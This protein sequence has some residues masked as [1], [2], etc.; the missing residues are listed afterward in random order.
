MLKFNKQEIYL[1]FEGLKCLMNTKKYSYKDIMPLVNKMLETGKIDTSRQD[2][3]K[4]PE[5]VNEEL[6]LHDKVKYDKQ[7]GFITGEINGKFI[8][9]IQGRTYLV[10][11]KELKEYSPKPEITTKPHMKFDEETQ[12]LLFEQ[13]V[14]CGIHQGNIPVK[15]NRCF[16]RY[17]QW[18]NAREDQQVRVSVEGI[19]TYVPKNKIV[20][21]ENVNDFANPENYVPGVLIDQVTEEATQNILVNVID[22]TSALGDADSIRIIIQNDMGEQEFQTAPKSMVRTLSI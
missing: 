22:Y 5:S 11:P 21:Y 17:D 18:E 10:D 9:M 7:T 1:I 19:V 20:I 3:F 4:I 8:V 12:K 16:V 13:Y 2:A 15:T 14:K 6:Q